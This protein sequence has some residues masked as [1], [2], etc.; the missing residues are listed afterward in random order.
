MDRESSIDPYMSG[1]STSRGVERLIT[2]LATRQHG[3]I[4]RRRLLEAGVPGHVIDHRVSLGRLVPLHLGVY[5]VGHRVL[6]QDGRIL[7]AVASHRAAGAV[8]KLWRSER[9]EVTVPRRCRRPGIRVHETVLPADEITI[10]RGIPVTTVSRTL[11]DLATVL[12]EH[13][14]DRA[15][16]EAEV[17]RRPDP[18]SLAELLERHPGRPGNRAIKSVLARLQL[19]GTTLRSELEARFL[20]LVTKARL[21]LPQ[22]N[23]LVRIG[24]RELVC[25]FVWP[26][27]RFVVELDGRAVHGTAA[28]FER[29]RARDRMLHA[30][31]G[32]VVRITWRQLETEPSAVV[33]DLRA[34]LR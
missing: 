31:G 28:A 16:N 11:F 3:V 18:L 22:V 27:Q 2:T 32:R 20:M 9:L 19:G 25:D 15:V 17:Q 14:L 26:A 4:G 23:A 12:P 33:V 8:W 5:A 7:A 6:T 29:D 24:N 1:R 34:I 21:P 10:E 13:Q 30:N